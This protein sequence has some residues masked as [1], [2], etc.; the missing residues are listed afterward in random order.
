MRRFLLKG[1]RS[2]ENKGMTLVSWDVVCIM[3]KQGVVR[4]LN[5]QTMNLGLLSK[6]VTKIMSSIEELAM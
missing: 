5:L 4:V 1:P 6:R 2:G 3:V